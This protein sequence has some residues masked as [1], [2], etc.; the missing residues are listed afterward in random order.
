M[1][2]YMTQLV[3]YRRAE[4]VSCRPISRLLGRHPCCEIGT[5]TNGEIDIHPR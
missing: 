5:R 1:S 3:R 2:F 4:H